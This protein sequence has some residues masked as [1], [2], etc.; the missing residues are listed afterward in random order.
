MFDA[1]DLIRKFKSSGGRIA[2]GLLVSLV[3]TP[4][5]VCPGWEVELNRLFLVEL[6]PSCSFSPL[7]CRQVVDKSCPRLSRLRL[8]LYVKSDGVVV[9]QWSY[10]TWSQTI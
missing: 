1:G 2:L 8:F 7:P 9:Q 4:R 5:V 10:V 6:H 3:R